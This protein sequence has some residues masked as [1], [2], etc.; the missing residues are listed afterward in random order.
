ML[1]VEKKHDYWSNV[2]GKKDDK[3]RS[4]SSRNI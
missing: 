4:V 2:L 1:V 3:Y